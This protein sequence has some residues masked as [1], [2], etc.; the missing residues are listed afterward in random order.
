VMNKYR[1]RGLLREVDGVGTRE[2][3]FG[4][5]LAQVQKHQ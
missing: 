5:I 1:E 4:R 3:V 2:Q